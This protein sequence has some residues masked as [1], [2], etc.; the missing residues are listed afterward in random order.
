[1]KSFGS[2]LVL[3]LFTF[4]GLNAKADCIKATPDASSHERVLLE[5]I[6]FDPAKGAVIKV[7]IGES[8]AYS[9][10]R[11]FYSHS[12][13]PIEMTLPLSEGGKENKNFDR[14]YAVVLRGAEQILEV[15]TDQGSIAE[16]GKYKLTSVKVL[17]RRQK[18]EICDSSECADV[19]LGGNLKVKEQR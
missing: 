17:P 9:A 10:G 6:G 3:A 8:D 19:D 11:S 16:G 4:G 18:V 14:M 15:C 2:S 13:R 12:T 7:I 1:M 5:S